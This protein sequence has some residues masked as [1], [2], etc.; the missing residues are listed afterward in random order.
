M[1]STVMPTVLPTAVPIYYET[2]WSILSTIGLINVLI[3]FLVIGITSF[4]PI[5]IVPI[6]VSSASAIADGL[7][8]YAFYAD[9]P[10]IPTAVAAGFADFFWLVR[11]SPCPNLQEERK[12][13]R[14][15]L[16]S[17]VLRSKK[18]ASPSIAI[19]S[20]SGSSQNTNGKRSC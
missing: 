18:R 3:G 5:T 11:Y 14:K 19:K 17:P 6:V 13:R 2:S 9:Y 4:S 12:R 10:I 8:Y 7:C 20:L 16:I 1:S 15:G